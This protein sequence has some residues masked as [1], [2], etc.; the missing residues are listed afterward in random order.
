MS[1]TIGNNKSSTPKEIKY[2][3]AGLFGEIEP[4]GSVITASTAAA[5]NVYTKFVTLDDIQVIRRQKLTAKQHSKFLKTDLTWKD[6]MLVR[7]PTV[8]LTKALHDG[9]K[10]GYAYFCFENK[11]YE[12]T[13]GPL[14]NSHPRLYP[15]S[16][17]NIALYDNVLDMK[18]TGLSEEDIN[19]VL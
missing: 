7:S 6:V 16:S 2:F 13:K 18:D 17:K 10:L 11:V 3:P 8:S 15:L 12:I 19:E 5:A 9:K 4:A 1:S 14:R